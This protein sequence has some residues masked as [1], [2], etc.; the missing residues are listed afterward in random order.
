IVTRPRVGVSLSV[1]IEPIKKNHLP[2]GE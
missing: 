2:Q 1:A